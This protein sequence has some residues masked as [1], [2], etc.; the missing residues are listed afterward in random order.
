M[1]REEKVY[2]FI[3]NFVREQEKWL[4]KLFE[5]ES[6]RFCMDP[7][8]ELIL[9]FHPSVQKALRR[10]VQKTIKKNLKV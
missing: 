4:F 2:R 9:E 8:G 3:D 6:V 1:N 7:S 5:D 10:R